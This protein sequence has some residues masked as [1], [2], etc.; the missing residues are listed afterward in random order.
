VLLTSARPIHDPAGR[1][2]GAV[3]VSL[4]ITE[5]KRG[6]EQRKL[7]VHEL[8]HRVKNTLAVVQAVASQTMRSAG[9]LAEAEGALI[10]RLVAL[11][12]AH[13]I[14][15]QENWS[16]ADLDDVIMA[17]ITA[18]SRPER[19]RLDGPQVRLPPSLALSIAMAV[20]ELTTNAIKYGALSRD[21]G[22]VSI[23]WTSTP[24]GGAEQLRIEW[25]EQDGPPVVP[26]ERRGFGTRMLARIFD[27]ERGRVSL[28]FDPTGLVAVMELDLARQG[29]AQ[30]G[31]AKA[32]APARPTASG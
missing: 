24:R 6:E 21:G 17:A 12:K 3:Q 23:D 18:H 16:G 10:N 26:P 7:L 8:N 32:T 27:S 14:L 15:T 5:R 31:E 11:A 30:Q 25:R 28:R 22:K 9:S 4:D 13:D 2:I 20:H 1:I 19:V 29:A